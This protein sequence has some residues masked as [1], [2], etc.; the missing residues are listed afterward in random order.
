M[1]IRTITL[2]EFQDFSENWEHQNFHQ[3]I[4]YA[5]LKSEEGYEYEMIGYF[6]GDSIV[7][8]ALVLVQMINSYLYAYVPEG[9][10]ID[11]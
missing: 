8:S 9:F 6:D 10:L 3:S 7:A 11:L 4:S 5:L 1:Q 2:K